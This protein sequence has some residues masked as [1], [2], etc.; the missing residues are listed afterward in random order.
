MY[1]DVDSTWPPVLP[2]PILLVLLSLHFRLRFQ[3]QEKL[4]FKNCVSR[5]YRAQKHVQK[6]LFRTVVNA[7][8]H[9]SRST[10]RISLFLISS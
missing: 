3:K 9:V 2:E 10:E 7:P 4:N 1:V 6:L 5:L 8:F